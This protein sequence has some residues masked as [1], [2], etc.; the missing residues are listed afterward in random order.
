MLVIIRDRVQALIKSGATLQQVL[1][2]RPTADYDPRF[3]A[4]SGTWT[5]DMFVEAVYASL[6]S[7]K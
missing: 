6:K 4:T 3:G 5:T 1:A 7:P 2:A